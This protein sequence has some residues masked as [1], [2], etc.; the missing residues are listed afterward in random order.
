MSALQQLQQQMLQAVMGGATQAH[1]IEV[2]GDVVADAQSRLDIYRHG[3]RVRLRDALANEFVG[4]Q[5]IA[6]RRFRALLDAYIDTH[7]SEHYNIRWYGSRLATFLDNTHRQTPQLAEMARLD[8]AISTA[9]DAANETHLSAGELAAVPPHAWADLRLSLLRDLQVLPCTCNVDAFRRAAD[10]GSERPHLRRYA[11][12]RHMLVW[13]L[14]TQVHYR[15]LE[16]DEWQV[17]SAA[18]HG[19]PF[20]QLCA[21]LAA[22][23]GETVALPRMVALL[24][25]WLS[26]GLVHGLGTAA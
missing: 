22:R 12:P 25:A 13:R 7:P 4:L 16:E 24:Q 1:M 23:H 19:A 6:G 18:Q 2:R 5:S 3:Y 8:W 10:N 15:R 14:D 26:A 20:A 17:L 11:A 21:T 9:F